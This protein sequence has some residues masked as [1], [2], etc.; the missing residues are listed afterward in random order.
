ME[1][2]RFYGRI[3]DII[4][5]TP[6]RIFFVHIGDQFVLKI[7]KIGAV[8]MYV[9]CNGVLSIGLAPFKDGLLAIA[10][11]LLTSRKETKKSKGKRKRKK[12]EKSWGSRYCKH[13]DLWNL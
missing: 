4:E 2:R 13:Q 10:A 11:G 9:A 1:I 8:Q 12:S 6:H 3:S 5:T 7:I